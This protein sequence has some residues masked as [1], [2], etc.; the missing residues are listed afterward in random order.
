MGDE[1]AEIS[2][3]DDRTFV[4]SFTISPG[5]LNIWVH[6]C[7]VETGTL[8]TFHMNLV[9]S[10][11]LD[12]EENLPQS[13]RRL[14]NI[15]EWGCESRRVQL[16]RFHERLHAWERVRFNERKQLSKLLKTPTKTPAKTPTTGNKKR[17]MPASSPVA[18]GQP[19]D[20]SEDELQEL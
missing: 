3:P 14:H 9:A 16:E 19:E 10:H 20:G 15:L 4:F 18:A 2:G 17:K 7:Y 5:I 1:R 8:D 11:S 12:D 6:W 13:R